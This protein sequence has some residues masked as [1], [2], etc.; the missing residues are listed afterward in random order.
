MTDLLPHGP[1]AIL[2]HVVIACTDTGCVAGVTIGPDSPFRQDNGVPAH[3]GVEYM[4]QACAAFSG[5]QALR[6]GAA[7]RMGF[8]L[9]TR[10]YQATRAWFADGAQ[11]AVAVDLV[12]RDDDIGVFDCCIRSDDETIASAQLIVAEP[13]DVAGLLSRQGGGDDG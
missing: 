7:P 2:L 1:E 10:H 9:G 4:A 6:A 12:Y 11:L 13:K 5:L 3:V 8:L